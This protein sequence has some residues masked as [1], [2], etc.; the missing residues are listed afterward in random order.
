MTL[1]RFLAGAGVLMMATAAPAKNILMIGIDDLRPEIAGLY[2]QDFAITPNLKRLTSRGATFQRAYCQVALCSPSR[3]SLLTGLR[4][5]T[6]RVY[7]IGPYFRETMPNGTGYDV[8]TLPQWLRQEGYWAA[9][10]GKIFHPGT[11]SGG[12]TKS[13]GGGDGGYPFMSNGS[14][15]EPYWFCDQFY[16]GT[17]QSPVAQDFPGVKAG[18]IQ[19]DEC[20]KCLN[21]TNGKPA[22]FVADC[23]DNCFPDG[24]VADYVVG[25]ITA[26]GADKLKQPFFLTAGMKRPHLGWFVPQKY[27]DMYD[28]SK[29]KIA[30]H[31]RPPNMTVTAFGTNSEIC[32]MDKVNCTTEQDGFRF[33]PEDM[34]QTLR[35]GYYSAVTF[36]D[37]QIGRILDAFDASEYAANTAILLW[38]DHGYQLGEHGLWAKITNFELATRV[39]LV[40]ALPD[41]P[42]ASKGKLIPQLVELLDVY[43]TIL[44]W[45]GVKKNPALQGKSLMPIINDPTLQN[46]SNASFSQIDRNVEMGLT[47]RTEN[48]RITEWVKFDLGTGRPIFNDSDPLELY[49]HHGDDESDF[50]AF[51]NDNLANDPTSRDLAIKMRD[52]LRA[53]WKN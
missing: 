2:G 49:D 3:T 52:L 16:N 7:E 34:H 11:S 31:I 22:W 37:S 25:R 10:G 23:P 43:P 45:T 20:L 29:I 4:P 35:K 8:K 17:F 18:C 14:W 40:V 12:P 26:T 51:E 47:M 32:G 30:E 15:S 24:A 41:H 19:S 28:V 36:M 42:P 13:E 33:V 5:D 46:F 21:L 53:N 50:D 38:G 39:P 6:S 1:G 48:Y 44:D 27:Y 9:G